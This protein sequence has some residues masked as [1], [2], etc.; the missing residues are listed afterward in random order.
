M[1]RCSFGKNE[2]WQSFIKSNGQHLPR[3]SSAT[4]SGGSRPTGCTVC[5]LLRPSRNDLIYIIT[6]SFCSFFSSIFIDLILKFYYLLY[7]LLLLLLNDYFYFERSMIFL[8]IILFETMQKNRDGRS[9]M[10][11]AMNYYFLFLCFLLFFFSFFCKYYGFDWIVKRR[12]EDR[13]ERIVI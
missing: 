2:V 7:L 9:F 3:V 11:A 12:L 8:E 5:P 13:M 4:G 10:L 6:I 1:V